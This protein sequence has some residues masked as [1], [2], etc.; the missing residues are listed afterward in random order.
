M[1]ISSSFLSIS[2]YLAFSA[3]SDL[4]TVDTHDTM[5]T[6]M[7]CHRSG[8]LAAIPVPVKPVGHLLRVYPYPCYTLSIVNIFFREAC[9]R[10]SELKSHPTHFWLTALSCTSIDLS[11][12]FLVKSLRVAAYFRYSP[13][14]LE[15]TMISGTMPEANA[16]T[17]QH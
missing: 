14:W 2:Q 7:V 13:V 1:T 8:I 9:I 5:K 3:A 12:P 15:S 10:M 17:S 11:S 6:A 16:P 4:I